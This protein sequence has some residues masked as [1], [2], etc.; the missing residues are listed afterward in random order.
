MAG[1]SRMQYPPDVRIIRTMCSGRVAWRH[2]DRAF[3]RRAALVLVSGCHPGDC[4]YMN[5]NL[6]T[7]RRIEKYWEKM[8]RLGLDKNRLQS[9]GLAQ[10]KERDSR[11]RSQKCMST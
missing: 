11:P 7:K 10:L 8:E 9:D 5:A 1:T 6:E 4:H 3:A 2:I